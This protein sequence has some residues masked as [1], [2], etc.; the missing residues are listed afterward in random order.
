MPEEK[1]GEC[2]SYEVLREGDETILRIDAERCPFLP[3]IEDSPLCMARAV[4]HLMETPE[5]TR[6]VFH[7]K[8][9]YE[10][11][12]EQ[13]KAL[14][15]IAS[16]YN[17]VVRHNAFTYTDAAGYADL[18]SIVYNWLKSDPVAAFVE[19][20]RLARRLHIMLDKSVDADKTEK[21][22][23][24][25]SYV[26]DK[27]EETRVVQSAKEHL[28]SYRLGDRAVYR[29]VFKPTIR[30][31]FMFTRVMASY[32]QNGEEIDNYS[33][34]NTEITVFN[35][36]DTVEKMYH[37]IPP[38]FKL[39]EEKYDLLDSARKIISEHKPTK[40]EFVDPERMR[41]V[42]YNIGRD[43]L[44]ELAAKRGVKL[45]FRE[46]E[47]LTSILVRYTVG[48]GLIEVL[49]EDE[50]IQDITVNSPMGH[51][52]MFIVHQ[53]HDECMTNIIPTANEGDS[54]ASKLRLIS[55]RPLDEA[56]PVMDTELLIPGARA[57][58]AVITQPLNPAG[59]AY[60]FRRH[61]D[62]PWTLPLFVK[63][64]M[65]SPLSAGVLSFLIDGARTMLIAGTRSSGKTSLLG[66]VMTEVIRKYR[67]VTI[68]DTLELPVSALKNLG[69]NIQSMKVAS[70]LTKGTNEVSADEG[71]RT[72][73]RMGDSCLIIGEVRSVEAKALYEAM[74]IGALANLVAGTVHGDSPYG[75]FDRVVND[76][77]VPKTSFK[78]TDVIVVANP[79]KSPDGLHRQ[80]RVTQITEVGK[81]WEQEPLMEKGFRDLLKYD[82]I[83]DSLEP[84]VDLLNGESE[85]IKG[86]ASN[87]KDWAGNWD[88]V[89]DNIM[90]RTNVKKAMVELSEKT[91]S[92]AIL[93]ADFVVPANDMFHRISDKIKEETGVMDSKRILFEWNDWLKR[94]VRKMSEKNA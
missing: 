61:R 4:E 81:Y 27:L 84:T 75:V 76:L 74:R 5:I 21:Q 22:L 92:T 31:D 24:L 78:A 89:W 19:L 34:G 29:L 69:Y 59:I 7:Q 8:R 6:I 54:W 67:Q 93:E 28:D 85:V 50:K 51:T 66:A 9:D 18:R 68:E 1:R 94:A 64:R 62:R 71:I 26:L 91:G 52:P 12:Y 63:N 56:N 17:H 60:A 58:A 86:I 11:D 46:L 33:V 41:Q 65:I 35:L 20:K 3:S 79:I 23:S 88:A 82:P 80:R 87:V 2:F 40:Q 39:S 37:I 42:F 14:L 57:R 15:E 72:T 90:L 32:P 45:R 10:Y 77:G 47:E 36:P 73:L 83:N 30:S 49:L 38:E 55:G 53:D 70:I 16:L 44:E 25:I 13:V 43:L 48:F